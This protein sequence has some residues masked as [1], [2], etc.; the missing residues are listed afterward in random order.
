MPGSSEHKFLPCQCHNSSSFRHEFIYASSTQ[1]VESYLALHC[2]LWRPT[3]SHR[4]QNQER[5]WL[6][7][8]TFETQ[9]GGW[10]GMLATKYNNHLELGLNTV[11]VEIGVVCLWGYKLNNQNTKRLSSSSIRSVILLTIYSFISIFSRT[12]TT[13][14]TK[15]RC[16]GYETSLVSLPWTV[17]TNGCP[18]KMGNKLQ[19]PNQL[20]MLEI[21]S[22]QLCLC[23]CLV[24]SRMPAMQNEDSSEMK[25]FFT[26]RN[27]LGDWMPRE[28]I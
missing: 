28:T 3:H 19:D 20:G 10:R 14:P 5:Y 12:T 15:I 26:L 23:F 13:P 27:L 18:M 4:S 1:L 9:G 7:E 11:F 8:R 6:T 16:G 21:S 2:T 17:A 22:I 24:E 25:F